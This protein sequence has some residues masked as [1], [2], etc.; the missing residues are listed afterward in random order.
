MN[1][2][3]FLKYLEALH[4]GDNPK[5]ELPVAQD[6]AVTLSSDPERVRTYFNERT[7]KRFNTSADIRAH[8]VEFARAA[9][10]LESQAITLN[11]RLG[12]RCK[13]TQA[14]LDREKLIEDTLDD[15]EMKLKAAVEVIQG[16][17]SPPKVAEHHGVNVT[18]LQRLTKKLLEAE[19]VSLKDLRQITTPRRKALA[20]KIFRESLRQIEQDRR[21]RIKGDGEFGRT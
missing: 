12:V 17:G 15:R 3:S 2:T 16:Y 20:D 21:D 1:A 13:R 14:S 11:N 6:L 5:A 8:T 4:A 7:S 18:V 10:I 9:G 19:G